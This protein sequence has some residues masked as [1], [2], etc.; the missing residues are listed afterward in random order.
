[1]MSN[2]R[3]DE[4]DGSV[5]REIVEVSRAE[6]GTRLVDFFGIHRDRIG[7]SGA[8]QLG[9][10]VR[11]EIA[12]GD[13]VSGKLVR[14]GVG[15]IRMVDEE[16]GSPIN[17]KL[18]E[19]WRGKV[20]DNPELD[21]DL[22][23]LSN[24]ASEK[25][26]WERVVGRVRF[27]AMYK[28]RFC[29]DSVNWR[30]WFVKPTQ[31][32][33]VRKHPSPPGSPYFKEITLLDFVR[34][35]VKAKQAKKEVDFVGPFGEAYK[36]IKKRGVK[37]KEQKDTGLMKW[38]PA[39]RQVTTRL[40]SLSDL[41]F[42]YLAEYSEGLVSMENIPIEIRHKLC[43]A[44]CDYGKMN[45]EFMKLIVAGSP[46]EVCV[47]DCS[48]MTTKQ[49]VD[50]FRACDTKNLKVLHLAISG[51]CKWDHAL[52]SEV[53][54]PGIFRALSS[55]SLKG[56]VHLTDKGLG[57]LVQLA[58]SLQSLDLSQC[59]LITAIG[60]NTLAIWY[61]KTLEELY[62]DDCQGID[63][64][65]MLPALT[66]FLNLQVLSV[67]GNYSVC[68]DFV[69]QFVAVRGSFMKELVFSSCKRLTDQTIK[70]IGSTCSSLVSLDISY[71]T[72]LTD[73]AL[74]HI[75]NGF[76]SIKHLELSHNAFSDEAVAALVEVSGK[77]LTELSIRDIR[78]VGPATAFSLAK[79]TGNL[80]SLDLSQCHHITEEMLGQIVD[81]C[82]SLRLL[83]LFGCSQI[84]NR[85]LDGHTNLN[86]EILGASPKSAARISSVTQNPPR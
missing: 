79:F 37:D 64:M 51:E 41:S 5:E 4:V 26:L 45:F 77:F 61:G 28:P 8:G 52:M 22:S 24:F 21:T 20:P 75:A 19:K 72:N 1:M 84:T 25:M 34:D 66:E 23:L 3:A 35:V 57:S 2:Q 15:E 80:V 85:F 16:L 36:R 76:G 6:E 40:P 78:K 27:E 63:A 33:N 82:T 48:W 46:S 43:R 12:F 32:V 86:L 29:R 54:P 47:P 50:V 53:F 71:I 74:Q 55:L 58:P 39:E 70:V 10:R 81:C 44:A 59:P 49:F 11:S 83:K 68:D 42:A 65:A 31:F 14:S 60:V 69:R 9:F 67:A 17:L 38:T 18:F 56:A 13:L 73:W 7:E 30:N 62:M